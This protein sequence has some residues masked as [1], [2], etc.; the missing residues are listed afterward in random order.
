[1]IECIDN[2]NDERM[3]NW[4][5][6]FHYDISKLHD[7]AKERHTIF[8]KMVSDSKVF[9]EIKFY[10]VKGLISREVQNLDNYY[11]SVNKMLM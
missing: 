2:R 4:S 7:V 9:L 8:E 11:V 6:N 10:N 5:C 1:M 3:V